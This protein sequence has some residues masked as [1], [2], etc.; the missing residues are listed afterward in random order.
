MIN[1]NNFLYNEN[2]TK[3]KTVSSQLVGCNA[4]NILKSDIKVK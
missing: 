2:N 1:E 3:I 4:E